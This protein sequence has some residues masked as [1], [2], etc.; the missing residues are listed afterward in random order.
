MER[1]Q[2]ILKALV[3]VLK[4][5]DLENI[6]DQ[7]SVISNIS[8]DMLQVVLKPVAP[9]KNERKAADDSKCISTNPAEG[10]EYGLETEFPLST[11]GR[12]S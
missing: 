10:S 6:I 1:P 5:L 9:S 12:S 4:E 3:L 2:K 7:E 8:S 11:I